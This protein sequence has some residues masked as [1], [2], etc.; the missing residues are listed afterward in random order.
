MGNVYIGIDNI[1]R[2]ISNA[3]VGVDGVARKIKQIFVGDANGIAR[4]VYTIK[5]GY[6]KLKTLYFGA[7]KDWEQVTSHDVTYKD[8]LSVIK[9][10]DNL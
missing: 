7:S 4:L 10:K 6:S 1:S 3:Y 2:K 9:I 8:I 5:K